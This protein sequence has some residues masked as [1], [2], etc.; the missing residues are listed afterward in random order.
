[1]LPVCLTPLSQYPPLLKK[2][3]VLSILQAFERRR[4][5]HF[6]IENYR[7]LQ[8]ILT[9]RSRGL[10]QTSFGEV[11]DLPSARDRLPGWNLRGGQAAPVSAFPADAPEIAVYAVITATDTVGI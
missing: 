4:T 7:G 2:C 6:P 8:N 1:M 11:C 5:G 9:N 3:S 10:A